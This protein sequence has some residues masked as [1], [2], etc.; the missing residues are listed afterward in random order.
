VQVTKHKNGVPYMVWEKLAGVRNE[1]LD[2]S[3]Y[4][5]A[6]AHLVGISRINWGNVE[7]KIRWQG[8]ALPVQ[9]NDRSRFDRKAPINS[10]ANQTPKRKTRIRK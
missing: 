5:L 8:N 3:V 2:I 1:P 6:A 7:E 10:Q 4:A 9:S